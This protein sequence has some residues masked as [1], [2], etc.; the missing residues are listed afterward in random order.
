[1]AAE[2]ARSD[3]KLWPPQNNRAKRLEVRPGRSADPD[4]KGLARQSAGAAKQN[5][6]GAGVRQHAG[7]NLSRRAREAANA[8]FQ[9][10]EGRLYAL[11]RASKGRYVYPRLCQCAREA[12]L[13][14]LH[15]S[16]T[17]RRQS[18]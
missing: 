16:S 15:S 1:M 7:R 11:E 10:R 13:K 4:T 2:T 6:H 14:R 12:R 3:S 17:E 18:G 5:Q 8:Q 9:D